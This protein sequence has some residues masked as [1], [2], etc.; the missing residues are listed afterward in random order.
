MLYLSIWSTPTE[1]LRL[2]RHVLSRV[3]SNVSRCTHVCMSRMDERLMLQFFFYFVDRTETIDLALTFDEV[4]MRLWRLLPWSK[5][6]QTFFFFLF[7]VSSIVFASSC[8]CYLKIYLSENEEIWDKAVRERQRRKKMIDIQLR[9][10]WMRIGEEK[11]NPVC[12][13]N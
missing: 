11:K 1:Q 8:C 2:H 6:D 3:R 4:C 10:R 9:H 12:F 13:S 7:F 5:F